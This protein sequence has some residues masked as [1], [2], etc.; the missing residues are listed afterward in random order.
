MSAPALV[1]A[2]RAALRGVVDPELGL[3]LVS[4]GLVRAIDVLD[5]P[6]GARVRVIH[7]LTTP[8]CPLESFLGEAIS[9]A[10]ASVDGVAEAESVLVWDPPWHPGLIEEGLL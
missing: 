3:D 2:V 6:A 7:T 8:G 4:L 10:A 9:A 1:E 5:G